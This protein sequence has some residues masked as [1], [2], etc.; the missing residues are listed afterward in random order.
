MPK[1]TVVIPTYNYARFLGEAIQSVLDQTFTDFELIVV[2][3]GSTDNTRAVVESFK[4]PRIRYIYQEHQ[5]V[6]VAENTVHRF[7]RGEYIT[8][9]GADDSY[10]PQ[11]LELKV[12]VL[13]ASPELA[14]V[15]SDAYIVDGHTGA[16]LGRRWHDK[17]FHYRFDLQRFTRYPLKELLTWGCFIAPQSALSRCKV[18]EEVGLFDE[19][20]IS[21]ED[22]DMYVRI[23]KRYPI[24]IMD[25]PLLKIKQHGDS[26]C[27]DWDKIYLG[28][29]KVLNKAINSYSF[30]REELRLLKVRLARTHFSYGKSMILNGNAAL[31]R[32]KLLEALKIRPLNIMPYVYLAGSLLGDGTI[33][34]LKSWSKR[35][36]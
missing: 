13:D 28:A 30:S 5:G 15:C 6:T 10:L 9:L 34:N 3:D 21:H 31:G 27:A 2:D 11:N 35:L 32:E 8:G 26:M 14:L 16:I 22:W 33:K 17:P 29:V 20:L 23:L 4:D 19:S 1:V 25:V 36:A 12:K 7:S 18:E 24:K